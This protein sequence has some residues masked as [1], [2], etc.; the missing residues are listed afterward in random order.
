[1]YRVFV[2]LLYCVGYRL[3]STQ[4]VWWVK[5]YSS[6]DD[7]PSHIFCIEHFCLLHSTMYT[8]LKDWNYLWINNSHWRDRHSNDSIALLYERGQAYEHAQTNAYCC[9]PGTPVCGYRSI[10]I[11]PHK[12]LVTLSM[13]LVAV[14]Y[15]HHCWLQF[16]TAMDGRMLPPMKHARVSCSLHPQR[17]TVR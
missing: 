5:G 9:H 6:I 12:M 1:M 13:T 14:M 15:D 4:C 10:A 3:T 2:C 11:G 7:C 16:A 8:Y 17:R